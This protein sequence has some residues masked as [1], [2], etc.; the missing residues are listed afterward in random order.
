MSAPGKPSDVT[1]ADVA[2]VMR[3]VRDIS[4]SIAAELI[5]KTRS[6]EEA[7]SVAHETLTSL[8]RWSE[9]KKS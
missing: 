9:S 5:R 2:A 3:R 8:L 4:D 6:R 7:V 1:P